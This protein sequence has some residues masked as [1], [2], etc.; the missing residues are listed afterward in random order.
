MSKADEGIEVRRIAVEDGDEGVLGLDGSA[1][2]GEVNRETK[3]DLDVIRRKLDRHLERLDGV[4]EK[5]T[6]LGVRRVSKKLTE[7]AGG[8]R[9]AEPWDGTGNIEAGGVHERGHEQ[10]MCRSLTT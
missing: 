4:R 6:G 10:T 7:T 8:A 1:T 3:P 2:L 9:R 5:S